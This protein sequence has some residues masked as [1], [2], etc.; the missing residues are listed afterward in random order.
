MPRMMGTVAPAKRAPKSYMLRPGTWLV[1]EE[2]SVTLALSSCCGV[3]TV[4]L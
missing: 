3:M 2:M 4:R 1:S